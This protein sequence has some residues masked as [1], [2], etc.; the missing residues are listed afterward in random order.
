MKLMDIN[1]WEKWYEKILNDLGF[2]R[3]CDEYCAE[4]LNKILKK[5]DGLSRDELYQ[6][7]HEK[8]NTDKAIVFGGGP[9]IKKDIEKLKDYNLD[10]YVL[11][12]ADGTTTALLEENIIPDIIVTDLDGKISDLLI[13]NSQNCIFVVHSHGDNIDNVKKYTKVLNNVLGTTQS[14]PLEKVYNFGGFTDGDRCVFLAIE[15]DFKK[16]LLAGMDFGDKITKYS[17][18]NIKND[19]EIGDEVKRK[20]LKYGEELVDWVKNNENVEISKIN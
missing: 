4:I 11:I 12:S 8:K 5:N 14:I 15:L 9:S 19:I 3:E 18:P 10:E 7:I 17:R 13:A 16:I 1:T 20:K 6:L 2:S